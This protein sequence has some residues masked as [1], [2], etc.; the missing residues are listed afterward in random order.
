MFSYAPMRSALLALFAVAVLIACSQ[1]NTTTKADVMP[2]GP[3]ASDIYGQWENK[4]AYPHVLYICPLKNSE[5]YTATFEHTSQGVF[6][7]HYWLG[8]FTIHN[9]TVYIRNMIQFTPPGAT[10]LPPETWNSPVPNSFQLTTDGF[11]Y[12]GIAGWTRQP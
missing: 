5:F 2:T 7:A 11:I 4:A 9:D 12:T 8:D 3:Q 6:V 1:P 10:P